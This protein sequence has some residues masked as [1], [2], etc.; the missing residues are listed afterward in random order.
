MNLQGNDFR[1][2]LAR[3]GGVIGFWET[4]YS[5]KIRIQKN[6]KFMNNTGVEQGGV[7]YNNYNWKKSIDI[8][9]D[10]ENNYIENNQ[11]FSG[12]LVKVVDYEK[13]SFTYKKLN[14][15]N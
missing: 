15:T 10:G 6:N 4:M 1:Q 13:F 5:V 14:Y 3:Y 2:N 7:F 8:W 9:W 11:A 12:N